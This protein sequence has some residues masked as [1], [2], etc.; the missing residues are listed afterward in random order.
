MCRPLKSVD[1]RQFKTSFNVLQAIGDQL[2]ELSQI[3][4]ETN[5]DDPAHADQFYRNIVFLKT[6]YER[7][8]TLT[9]HELDS[10]TS[11]SLD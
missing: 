1:V 2:V 9:R 11:V 6:Y 5:F 10:R 4:A 3:A 7:C 8:E